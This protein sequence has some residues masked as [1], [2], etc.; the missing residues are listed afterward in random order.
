MFSKQD[1]HDYTLEICRCIS[2]IVRQVERGLNVNT[3]FTQ[4]VGSYGWRITNE[5]EIAI[6]RHFDK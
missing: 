3:V 5:S 1:N 4:A 2:F 6:K